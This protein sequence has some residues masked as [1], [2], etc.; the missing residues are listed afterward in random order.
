M[1]SVKM[2]GFFF[3]IFSFSRGNR[4]GLGR[5]GIW[6]VLPVVSGRVKLDI[7]RFFPKDG[8]ALEKLPRELSQSQTLSSNRNIPV[9]SANPNHTF[10]EENAFNPTQ[11]HPTSPESRRISCVKSQKK[12]ASQRGGQKTEETLRINTSWNV[13]FWSSQGNVGSSAAWLSQQ[14]LSDARC[15]LRVTSSDVCGRPSVRGGQTP[16]RVGSRRG[17]LGSV[18]GLGA[19]PS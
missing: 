11:A 16:A 7:R 10:H 13:Y 12:K 3:C 1:L 17:T 2:R 4:A 6:S 18:S 8:W 15:A 19:D 5:E 14:Y 9:P